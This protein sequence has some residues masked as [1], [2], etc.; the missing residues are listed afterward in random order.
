MH[1]FMLPFAS[2][3]RVSKPPDQQRRRSRRLWL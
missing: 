3:Q 1:T 2:I